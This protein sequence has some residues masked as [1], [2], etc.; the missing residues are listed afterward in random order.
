M[1]DSYRNQG[2]EEQ[3]QV[4]GKNRMVCMYGGWGDMEGGVGG[5]S[6]GRCMPASKRGLENSSSKVRPGPQLNMGGHQHKVS[7]QMALHDVI[8]ICCTAAREVG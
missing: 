5:H 2:E 4:L 6:T 3:T 7:K 1:S 8:I